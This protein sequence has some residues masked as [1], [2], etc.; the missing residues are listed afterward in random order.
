MSDTWR[1]DI[2]QNGRYRTISLTLCVILHISASNPEDL[3]DFKKIYLAQFFFCCFDQIWLQK[4][5]G[6]LVTPILVN[7]GIANGLILPSVSM[8]D[9]YFVHTTKNVVHQNLTHTSQEDVQ[10]T[11]WCSL[12]ANSRGRVPHQRG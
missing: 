4:W 5:S 6:L 12:F 8:D 3:F 1:Y 9:P 10:C 7:W 11:K 2:A